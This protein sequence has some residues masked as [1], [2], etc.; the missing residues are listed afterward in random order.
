MNEARQMTDKQEVGDTTNELLK[1]LKDLVN[2]CVNQQ[3][4]KCLEKDF[5]LKKYYVWII[6][7]KDGLSANNIHFLPQTRVTRPFKSQAKDHILWSVTNMNEI[8]YE[9]NVISDELANYIIHNKPKFH[10]QT[11][12]M[13]ENQLK[14]KIE[15]IENYV[16]DGSIT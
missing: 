11:V 14:N 8:K 1:Y 2:E 15:K 3:A 16:L 4:E 6:F 10:D 9:W 5:T 13:A 12:K 7:R